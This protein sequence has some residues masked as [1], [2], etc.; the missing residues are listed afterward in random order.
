MHDKDGRGIPR[1]PS[2]SS[3]AE[4]L[5]AELKANLKRRKEQAR[6]RRNAGGSRPAKQDESGK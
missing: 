1:K 6:T 3:R 2:G 4:R 5:A